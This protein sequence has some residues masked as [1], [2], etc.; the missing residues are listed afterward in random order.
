MTPGSPAAT[1]VQRV[2][3][4]DL[5]ELLGDPRRRSPRVRD[6]GCGHERRFYANETLDG[7]CSRVLASAVSWRR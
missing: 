6:S 4:D 3:R 5:V 7:V 2:D 1:E